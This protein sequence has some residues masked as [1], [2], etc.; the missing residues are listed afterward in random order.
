VP[1]A[2]RTAGAQARFEMGLRFVQL[3]ADA[4]KLLLHVLGSEND[5]EPP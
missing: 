3:N 5:W 1:V 2:Y 4:M